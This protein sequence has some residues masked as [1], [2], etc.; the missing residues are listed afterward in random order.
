MRI[1]LHLK[2]VQRYKIILTFTLCCPDFFM[3]SRK[4]P[5]FSLKKRQKCMP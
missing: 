1:F 4:K 2:T 3:E 5:S